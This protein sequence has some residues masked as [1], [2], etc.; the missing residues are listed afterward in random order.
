MLLRNIFFCHTAFF[1]LL[2]S[3][4]HFF[5]RT[6]FFIAC[7]P[8]AYIFFYAC[9]PP[10]LFFGHTTFVFYLLASLPHYFLY[11]FI[12]V[13]QKLFIYFLFACFPTAFF[14]FVALLC[15]FLMR[16][17]LP[18]YFLVTLL[19]FFTCL[20]PYRTIFSKKKLARRIYSSI[21]CLIASLPHPFFVAHCFAFFLMRASLPHYFLV[22]L[23]LF[24]TC[25]L[26]YRTIFPNFCLAECIY[27]FLLASFPTAFFFFVALLC[28]FF[29]ACF[30]SALFFGHTTLVFYLFASLLHYFLY[31]FLSP[32]IYLFFACLLP[33]RIFVL[34]FLSHGFFCLL[35][36]CWLVLTSLPFVSSSFLP[37]PVRFSYSLLR[38]VPLPCPAAAQKLDQQQ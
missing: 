20:L 4:P 38:Y 23:L 2:A 36:F 8:T 6:A 34:L 1:L 11:L 28:F 5:S 12:F 31:F 33:Y 35:F 13:S 27:L 17:S 14:F 26:P 30:P 25:L 24:F 3:L 7:F 16:A 18:H 9:F 32:R 37:V 22:T 29:N 15:F 19:L 10:A 21:F